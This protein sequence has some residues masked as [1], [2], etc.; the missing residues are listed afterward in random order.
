MTKENDVL[1]SSNSKKSN[2]FSNL[3]E[4][5]INFERLLNE[6]SNQFKETVNVMFQGADMPETKSDGEPPRLSSDRFDT[7]NVRIEKMTETAN[8]MRQELTEVYKFFENG[9]K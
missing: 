3:E 2:K 6:I 9:G 5:L 4:E 7:M 1:V 8:E